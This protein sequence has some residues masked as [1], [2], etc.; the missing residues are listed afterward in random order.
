M[1][2][3]LKAQAAAILGSALDFLVTLLL[4]QGLHRG[5][6]LGNLAG[7]ITGAIIQF[8]LCRN[9]AFDAG[10]GRVSLQ[11]IKFVFVWCGNILLSAGGLY[12]CVHFLQIH[13]L[14]A[15]TMISILLG[16]TYQYFMQKYFVFGRSS[17]LAGAV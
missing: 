5:Y 11:M 2:T 4:V 15:K 9:W 7:N 10:G 8:I 12:L 1:I 3:F 14:L 6:I 17:L 13:Y 16:L